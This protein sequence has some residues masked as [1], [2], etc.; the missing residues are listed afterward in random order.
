MDARKRVFLLRGVLEMDHV[1][2]DTTVSFYAA[3]QTGV[4]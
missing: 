2:P 3:I 1:G 4:F